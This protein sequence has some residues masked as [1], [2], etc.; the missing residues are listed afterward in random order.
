MTFVDVKDL[1]EG[2]AIQAFRVG[3]TNEH[4]HYALCNSDITSMHEL[5]SRV[6]VLIEAEEIRISPIGR[7]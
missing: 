2:F 7:G 1:N 5:V 4:V 6:Q 3:V